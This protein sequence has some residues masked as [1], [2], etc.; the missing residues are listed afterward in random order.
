MR[1]GVGRARLS[2]VRFD[3]GRSGGA[4]GRPVAGVRGAGAN[5]RRLR[6]LRARG[7]ASPARGLSVGAVA[8][9]A[10]LPSRRRVR[11]DAVRGAQARIALRRGAQASSPKRGGIRGGRARTASRCGESGAQAGPSAD[12][13]RAQARIARR[14][15]VQ[16]AAAAGR[17]VSWG[18]A[19]HAR[20]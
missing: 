8:G 19:S 15:S 13:R 2:G 16:A 7:R 5:R 4:R 3:R 1:A 20:G 18:F 14:L 17:D 9:R 6:C 11:G 10:G 12:A